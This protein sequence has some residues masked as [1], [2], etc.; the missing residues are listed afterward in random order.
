M[1]HVFLLGA[2]V[3]LLVVGALVSLA[4]ARDRTLSGWVAFGAATA[5]ASAVFA[6]VADVFRAGAGPETVLLRLPV[7]GAAWTVG[8]DPLSAFFL[9]IAATIGVLSTLFS[10]RYMSHFERDSVARFYPVLLIFLAFVVGVLITT[11]FLFFLGVLGADDATSFFL[12][13][14]E[15]ESPTSQRAGRKYLIVT[16][17]AT[18]GL[19]P[20]RSCCGGCRAGSTSMRCAMPSVP[21]WKRGPCWGTW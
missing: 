15:R 12:V 4:L 11:D 10:V 14:F 1:S 13:A 7:L 9:A 18:L 5:A 16:H 3:A 2:A 21:C 20:R 17:A 19:S 8:V 6:V